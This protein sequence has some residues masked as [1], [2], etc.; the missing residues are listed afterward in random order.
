MC[1]TALLLDCNVTTTDSLSPH[2]GEKSIQNQLRCTVGSQACECELRSYTS[3]LHKRC[4]VRCSC[5]D[6]KIKTIDSLPLLN[7]HALEEHAHTH[8]HILKGTF[9]SKCLHKHP[10]PHLQASVCRQANFKNPYA[11]SFSV[12]DTHTY[13][14]ARSHSHA[15][16]VRWITVGFLSCK[17]VGFLLCHKTF[18]SQKERLILTTPRVNLGHALLTPLQTHRR[19]K[20][21][22]DKPTSSKDNNSRRQATGV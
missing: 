13:M 7:V 17:S 18:G 5:V 21:V 16:L 20:T 10:N 6:V 3:W 8:T 1:T 2:R 12:A 9:W 4:G 11:V 15:G 22:I 19:R 14:P